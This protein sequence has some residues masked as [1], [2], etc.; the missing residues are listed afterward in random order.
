MSSGYMENLQ[1]CLSVPILRVVVL[2]PGLLTMATMAERL[3]VAFVPE[4]RRITTMRDDMINVGR[5]HIPF[6]LHALHTQRMRC[7]VTFPGFLPSGTIPTLRGGAHL[8]RVLAGMLV[9]VFLSPGYQPR[10]AGMGAGMVWKM[11]HKLLDH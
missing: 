6:L 8:F 4:E 2:A 5:F 1:I 3:P 10:T 7:Q 9:T 11:R